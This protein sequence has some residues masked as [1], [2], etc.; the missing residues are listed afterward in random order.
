MIG[1]YVYILSNHARSVLYV[2]VTN[3]LERRIFEHRNNQGCSFTKKY[4]CMSL[5]YYEIFE[6]I[7]DAILREKQLKNWHREWKLNLI[8]SFNPNLKDLSLEWML[9]P[10]TSSG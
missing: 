6:K 9:D 3:N 10:E 8:R 4:R 1:G 7:T 5:L 2:G